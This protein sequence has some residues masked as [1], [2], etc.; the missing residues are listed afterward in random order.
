M[1]HGVPFTK[2]T[3]SG[4]D[5]I[6]LDHREP[7][8]AEDDIAPFARAVCRR[9]L[10]L[11]ADGVLLIERSPRTDVHFRWRYVNADGSHGEMCGNGA[12]CGARFAVRLG[13][14][15]ARCR[16]ETDAGDVAAHVPDAHHQPRV[17]LDM[18]DVELPVQS[19][20]LDVEGRPWQVG[21]LLAGVPHAVTLVDDADTGF[22]HAAFD[23]WGRAVRH[24]PA[25]GRAGTNANVVH[26]VDRH[27]LRMRTWERGVEAET[28][29]C[30]T[31]AVASAIVACTSGMVAPPVRVVV[32]SGEVL[33]VGLAVGPDRVRDIRLAGEARFVASGTIDP[34]L[35]MD[36][37][38]G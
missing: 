17:E 1:S 24:H 22:D 21:R 6:V 23:R 3:G 7:F 36:G 31:G 34:E 26:V 30:G 9:G 38:R 11:G 33:E 12:M 35:W 18:P 8:L 14:A 20:T 25:F 2:M 32:S 27:T 28:L 10:G 4:N 19:L 16:F 5:F 29:A 37:A 15:P 13:I